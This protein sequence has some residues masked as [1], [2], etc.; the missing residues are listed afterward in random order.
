M[1]Y[2]GDRVGM[3]T[4]NPTQARAAQ[5]TYNLDDLISPN[6]ELNQN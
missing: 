2:N 6:N 4:S 3:M 5:G 1:S